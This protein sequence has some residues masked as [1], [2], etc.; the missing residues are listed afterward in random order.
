MN[1]PGL[2]TAT[3]ADAEAITKE[4]LKE[5][6]PE[7]VIAFGAKCYARLRAHQLERGLIPEFD[8][9]MWVATDPARRAELWHG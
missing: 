9:P 2:K 7:E 8:G 5:Q 1:S 6:T 3:N 4:W